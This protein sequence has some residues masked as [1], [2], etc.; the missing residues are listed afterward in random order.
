MKAAS[1]QSLTDDRQVVT[2][3]FFGL[4]TE[5]SDSS[6]AKRLGADTTPPFSDTKYKEP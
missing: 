5:P 6:T 2:T 3:L 1:R 4:T